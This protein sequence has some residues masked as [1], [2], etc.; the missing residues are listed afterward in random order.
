M[1]LIITQKN[2]SNGH[3]V[4]EVP[5]ISR[6]MAMVNDT[7]YLIFWQ[8]SSMNT[9][10]TQL[11]EKR[12]LLHIVLSINEEFLPLLIGQPQRQHST[13]LVIHEISISWSYLVRNSKKLIILEW[14]IYGKLFNKSS[15]KAQMG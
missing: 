5:T 12:L 3:A 6:N 7:L 9:I 1:N 4:T 13:H 8:T 10:S 15:L 2:L 11:L 14:V